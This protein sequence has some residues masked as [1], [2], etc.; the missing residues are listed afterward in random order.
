MPFCQR[1]SRGSFRHYNNDYSSEYDGSIS[2]TTVGS[3]KNCNA[4]VDITQPPN[5]KYTE[6]GVHDEREGAFLPQYGLLTELFR[7][8]LQK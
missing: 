2:T 1:L 8:Y 4:N 7:I 6:S 5:G 3:L